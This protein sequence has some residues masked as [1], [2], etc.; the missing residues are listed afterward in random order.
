MAEL[1]PT[2]TAVCGLGESQTYSWLNKQANV[3]AWYLLSEGVARDRMVAVALDRSPRFVMV[4]LGIL[5]S[6]APYAAFDLP[7]PRCRLRCAAVV[8]RLVT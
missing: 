2:A 5:K 6:G 1:Y 8:H 4:I 7:A 3:F